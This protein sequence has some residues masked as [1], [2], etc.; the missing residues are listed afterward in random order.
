MEVSLVQF[1]ILRQLRFSLPYLF[2][3]QPG[4]LFLL[5]HDYDIL[6]HD[7]HEVPLLNTVRSRQRS[8]SFR[9]MIYYII[10]IALPTITSY[11]S[12]VIFCTSKRNTTSKRIPEAL[13]PLDHLPS[14]IS[15]L[16]RTPEHQRHDGDN[17]NYQPV[18]NQACLNPWSVCWGVL[19]TEN[20][21]PDDT[22]DTTKTNQCR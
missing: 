13:L 20:C 14:L 1:P 12:P 19:F 15:F 17:D 18:G 7:N 4:R 10:K 11:N 3:P 16:I 21:A 8:K 9:H 22:T 2:V 5:L 6:V